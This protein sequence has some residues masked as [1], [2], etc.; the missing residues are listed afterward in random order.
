MSETTT[1]AT[2]TSRSVRLP[3]LKVPVVEVA[4]SETALVWYGALQIG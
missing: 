1:L 3:V 2:A 4:I